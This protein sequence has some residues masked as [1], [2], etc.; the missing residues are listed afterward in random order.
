MSGFNSSGNNINP[1]LGGG[2]G[3]VA[4]AI[5]IDVTLV[6]GGISGYFLIN[7]PDGTLGQVNPTTYTGFP[8]EV[9]VTSV[10]SS[11]AYSILFT[12]PIG[13]TLGASANFGYL[14]STSVAFNSILT[15][16]ANSQASFSLTRAR[17][18]TAIVVNGDRLGAISMSGYDGAVYQGTAGIES[19]A[20]GTVSAGNV[21]ASL[22]FLTS[23]TTTAALSSKMF[24]GP[25]GVV[26]IGWGAF[27]ASATA[28]L[29]VKSPGALSSD[30]A[31][32]I[33]N[34]TSTSDLFKVAGN[35]DVNFN[36]ISGN[37]LLT[38][39]ASGAFA[40]GLISNIANAG[41]TDVLI[42]YGSSFGNN[43]TTNRVAIGPSASS[44]AYYSVS[45]G[46]GASVSG[47]G[48]IAVGTFSQASGQGSH[49]FGIN[50]RSSGTAS[51]MI[52][53]NYNFAQ[54]NNISNSFMLQLGLAGSAGNFQDFFISGKS[55]VVLRNNTALTAATHYDTTAT[56]T[57]TIHNGT[58]T[59]GVI[60]DAIQIYAKDTTEGTPKSALAIFS[61]TVP[62]AG[63][64]VPDTKVRVWW[65]GVQYYL[66]LE[67]IP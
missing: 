31:F 61:E 27:T 36:D 24:V 41:A 17:A 38:L 54:T 3:G 25:T 60:A 23:N 18:G 62:A 26:A 4:T 9:D 33:T 55:N 37:N 19:V 56:N 47:D 14:E 39:K 22:H 42:G 32:R 5:A 50:M 67:A 29:D 1:P 58:Q 21:P 20:S 46:Y 2:G 28:R 66:G 43:T 40:L 53:S 49:S 10:L 15:D 7:N 59:S 11:S 34:N 16:S 44:S 8:I 52:G 48:G 13:G 35:G 57:Y 30:I 65:N 64:F 6:T 45:V 12:N 51:I 63:V